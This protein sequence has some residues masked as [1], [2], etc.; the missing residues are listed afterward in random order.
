MASSLSIPMLKATSNNF[1]EFQSKLRRVLLSTGLWHICDPE[2]MILTRPSIKVEKGATQVLGYV[3]P[4]PAEHDDLLY[5]A[6][7]LQ[8]HEVVLLVSNSLCFSLHHLLEPHPVPPDNMLGRADY[9]SID[10][11]FRPSNEWTKSEI[12]Y[13][14]EAIA[15]TNPR[16]TY[17]L[18]TK[19][20]HEATSA[21]VPLTHYQAAVKFARLIQPLN[22]AYI[23]VL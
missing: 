22:S 11:H 6:E 13:R 15:L 21:G 17:N 19:V 1:L 3:A 5:R 16:D 12:L 8:N 20:F 10:N 14:W 2:A 9:L 7:V 18:I 23:P 4:T